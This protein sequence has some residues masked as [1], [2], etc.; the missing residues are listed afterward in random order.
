MN[1]A[2][3]HAARFLLSIGCWI[4]A[5]VL[6]T[7]GGFA[8]QKSQNP[9]RAACGPAIVHMQVQS[10]KSKDE[11]PLPPGKARV[12]V[13][14]VFRKPSFEFFL[15]PTILIGMDGSWLGA[16]RNRS[17]LALPIEPGD[18]H[19]CAEWNSTLQKRLPA[20]ASLKAD[21]GKTYYFRAR[22]MYPGGLDFQQLDPDEGRLLVSHSH[23]LIASARK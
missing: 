14:G 9:V 7:S 22:I 20:L 2:P 8:Q 17:Y 11:T 3:K 5:F 16:T 23:L 19:L 4:S 12:Y 15:D 13:V 6:M 21:A 18:H 1:R 10:S